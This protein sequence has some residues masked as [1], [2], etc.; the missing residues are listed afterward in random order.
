ML[1]ELKYCSITFWGKVTWDYL[2]KNK[3]LNI[4]FGDQDKNLKS[5]DADNVINLLMQNV[6]KWPNIL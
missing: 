5:C 4:C 6:Q 2:D 1:T 3:I